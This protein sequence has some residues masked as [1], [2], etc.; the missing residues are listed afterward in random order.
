MTLKLYRSAGIKFVTLV[1]EDKEMIPVPPPDDLCTKR[2]SLFS[3]NVC[4]KMFFG[5]MVE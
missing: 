2:G 1:G 3:G 4:K 5:Y